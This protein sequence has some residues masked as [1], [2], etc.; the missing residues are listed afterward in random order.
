MD[1]AGNLTKTISLVGWECSE[2]DNLLV[3]LNTLFHIISKY[4]CDRCVLATYARGWLCG[5]SYQ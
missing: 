1:S 3:N 4:S 5:W 2:M